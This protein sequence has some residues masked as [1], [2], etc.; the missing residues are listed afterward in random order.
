MPPYQTA[1]RL[2]E[3]EFTGLREILGVHGDE[4]LGPR[5]LVKITLMT[6]AGNDVEAQLVVRLIPGRFEPLGFACE[7]TASPSETA[8]VVWPADS[9]DFSSSDPPEF[10][11]T[12]AARVT[13]ELALRALGDDYIRAKNQAVEADQAAARGVSAC[14]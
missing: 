5:V 11:R 14:A 12:L 13:Q 7:L 10:L 8:Q 2:A 6:P 4:K 1:R 3:Y 9:S